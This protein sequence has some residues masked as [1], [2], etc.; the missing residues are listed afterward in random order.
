M[1][2]GAI[3]PSDRAAE[4]ELQGYGGGDAIASIFQ[5]G[6]VSSIRLFS[7]CFTRRIVIPIL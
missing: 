1:I 7:C 3:A 4:T 2:F 6:S 5:Q